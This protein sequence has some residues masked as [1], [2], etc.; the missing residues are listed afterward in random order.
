MIQSSKDSGESLV[1]LRIVLQKIFNSLNP[2]VISS[3]DVSPIQESIC[4]EIAMRTSFNFSFSAQDSEFV[5]IVL[6]Q[7]KAGHI[8]GLELFDGFQ[9]PGIGFAVNFDVF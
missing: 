3:P 6:F 2:A 7:I 9:V 5:K 4:A 1:A 8:P